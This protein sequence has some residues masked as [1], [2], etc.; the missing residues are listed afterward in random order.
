MNGHKLIHP[1]TGS[2]CLA[3]CHNAFVMSKI[4]QLA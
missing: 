3:Q 4:S 2:P 1:H